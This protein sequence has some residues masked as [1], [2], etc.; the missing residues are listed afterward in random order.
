[1]ARL[2]LDAPGRPRGECQALTAKTR[3]ALPQ[4]VVSQIQT[5]AWGRLYLFTD[6]GV[7]RLTVA[8]GQGLD[9]R[10]GGVFRRRGR[11]AGDEFQRLLRRSPRPDLGGATGGAAVLDPA[12]PELRRA[13]R[14][15]R[16]RCG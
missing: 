14:A 5:D 11:P 6:W 10:P 7:T 15:G 12:P 13:R 3:P 8:P 2:R 9:I 4:A 16:R 1:M